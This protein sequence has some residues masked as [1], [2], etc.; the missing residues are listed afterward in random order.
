MRRLMP[1]ARLLIAS[2]NRGKVDEIATLLASFEVE[3]V[4]SAALGLI[5]PDETGDSFI[6]NALLK[7]RVAARAANLPALGDDSGL[8]VD[9]LGG[10]PGIYS[11][12]WAETAAGERNWN[13]AMERVHSALCAASDSQDACMARFVCALAIA[14]PNG[15]EIS[16]EG[17][18]DGTIIWPPR[19]VQGFGYDPIFQPCGSTQSFGEMAADEKATLSHRT[20][21][22]EKLIAM[23]F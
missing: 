5:E 21:A 9:A 8:V 12:R 13:Y 3:I 6:A 19:G 20:R 16:V 17:H 15:D 22:F 11:A 18:V 7:A 10:A 23:V 14:W 2:H 4:H 1:H